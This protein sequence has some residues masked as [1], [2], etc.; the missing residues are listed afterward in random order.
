METFTAEFSSRIQ[1]GLLA[2]LGPDVIATLADVWAF[3]LKTL[4]LIAAGRTGRTF[5]EQSESSV[6]LL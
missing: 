4:A 2:T 1:G 3:R 6:M 5:E